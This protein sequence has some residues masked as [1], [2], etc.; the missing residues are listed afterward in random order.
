MTAPEVNGTFKGL[1]LPA[2]VLQKIYTTNA[3]TM[4]GI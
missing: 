2:T 3:K 1:G 4:Y